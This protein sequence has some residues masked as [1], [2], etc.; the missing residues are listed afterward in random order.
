MGCVISDTYDTVKKNRPPFFFFFGYLTNSRLP[1]SQP[2]HEN[3]LLLSFYSFP[4][5]DGGQ[6]GEFGVCICNMIPLQKAKK[7]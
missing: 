4:R 1:T 5:R 3:D 6:R 7:K 2:E